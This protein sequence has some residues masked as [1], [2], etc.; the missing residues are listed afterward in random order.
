MWTVEEVSSEAEG[1][2]GEVF[3]RGLY[4]FER[5]Y[6]NTSVSVVLKNPSGKGSTLDYLRTA[7][8]VAPSVLPD[9]V[10][11]E[12]DD[13]ANAARTGTLVPLDELVSAD[14]LDDLM[15]A[16][17]VAGTVDGKMMGIPFELDAEHLVYNTN[18]VAQ[19]PITWTGVLSSDTIYSFPA[20]GRNGLVND[21]F[22]IQYLAAGGT[23]QDEEGEPA[24]NEQVLRSVLDYYRQGVDLGVIPPEVLD[25]GTTSETWAGYVAA[26]VGITHVKASDYLANRDV[27]RSTEYRDIPTRDGTPLTITRGRVLA[28]T[29]N[30]PVQQDVAARLLEW[31]LAPDNN[32]TWAQAS[33]QLPTRYST[34]Q[35]LDEG[36]P[37]WMFLQHLLEVA[38]PPPAFVDYD[39]VGR[40]L[41]QA[42]VEVI[43]GEATPEEA[44]AS[45]VDALAR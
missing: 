35:Q 21:A 5:A 9:I 30:D 10:V 22:L 25:I 15:P 27:L 1:K 7:S 39:Q 3:A 40:V 43:S 38:I 14:L 4:T 24:L 37:Y 12:T 33:S 20:K 11:L 19:T 26:E 29:T 32:V 17:R 23:L 6:P 2:T 42:V 13:L 18:K 34:F 31:L 41:Q 16:A 36:D 45:A 44:A 8:L 28:V